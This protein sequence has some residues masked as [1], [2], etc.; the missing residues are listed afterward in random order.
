MT[1]KE[2]AI[3]QQIMNEND[4]T[5][6]TQLYRYQTAR[7]IET[8]KDGSTYIRAKVK[9]L[10]IVIDPYQGDGH[11]FHAANIGSGLAFTLSREDE[12]RTSD[13]VCVKVTLKDILDQ[14]G[15]IYQVTSVPEYL[16]SFFMSI[17]E[18]KVRAWLCD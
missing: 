12:F 13:N 8:G 17:P 16:T 5:F 2:R 10:E 7:Y 6:D 14:G 4:L 15:L 3:I 9:P 1:E 11:S 18:G